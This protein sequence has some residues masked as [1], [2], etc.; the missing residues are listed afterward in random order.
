MDHVIPSW[1]K[2]SPV[3]FLT[4]CTSPRGKN[5]LCHPEASSAAFDAV[6]HYHSGLRWHTS[7]FL[8]MP[9][10]L[11]ALIAFPRIESMQQ[12]IRSW[13]HYLARHQHI[14]WQRDYFDHRIRDHN[15][16]QEK[17]AYIRQNP[18]RAGL[19]ASQELWPYIWEPEP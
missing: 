18:V 8:L 16:L 6:H 3:F 12:V 9:D 10:H 2:G 14:E 19:V 7:L 13:K 15:S 17:A 5:Q 4:I 11:H 1:V